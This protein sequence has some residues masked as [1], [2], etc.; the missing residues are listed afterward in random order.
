M[1]TSAQWW[2]E[3]KNDPAKFNE[4]LLKQYRGE[5]T[6]SQRILEV[7]M[8]AENPA[9]V[10]ILYTIANDEAQHAWWVKEL[11]DARGIKVTDDSANAEKRYWATVKQSIKDFSTA[12]AIA[13]HAEAMRLERINTIAMDPD[14]PED[15]REVFK[16]ILTDELFHER[17]FRELAGTEA[18]ADTKANA[19]EGRRVLGLVA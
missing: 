10:N 3:V 6:A 7:A 8:D 4:W 2:A 15:V 1:R 13:A 11:L 5:V 19:D 14:A 17:A 18:M 16:R 9:Q 12:M